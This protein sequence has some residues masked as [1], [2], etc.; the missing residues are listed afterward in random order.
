MIPVLSKMKCPHKCHTMFFVVKC[1]SGCYSRYP[2]AFVYKNYFIITLGNGCLFDAT[3]FVGCGSVKNVKSC[4][5]S[6]IRSKKV[7]K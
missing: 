4:R 5:D 2:L 7:Y 3:P 1:R 6:H